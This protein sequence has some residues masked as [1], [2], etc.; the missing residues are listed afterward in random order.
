MSAFDKIIGYENIKEELKWYSDILKNP[1]D[2][3][4]LGVSGP[5]GLLL[6]G[7]PG[8]GKSMMAKALIS[9]SGCKAYTL[10]KNLPNGDFVK[11][12]KRIFDEAA[13]NAP[14]IVLL[15][16]VD[17]FANCD[18]SNKDAEEYVT[19]QACMD[20]YRGKNI[21][22][23]ATANDRYY[24]PDSL[25]RPGRFDK[26]IN[27]GLPNREESAQ[28][29]DYYLKSKAIDVDV[30]SKEVSRL[31]AGN[32]CAALEN[33]I[34]EAGIMAAYQKKPLIQREDI[35]NACIRFIYG[36][37]IVSEIKNIENAEL[38]ALHEAGH[39]VVAEILQP[40]SVNV[41]YLG[42][43]NGSMRGFAAI[44]RKNAGFYDFEG[45]EF[46]ILH[47]LGGKAAVEVIKGKKAVG[48]GSDMEDVF[49]DVRNL[50]ENECAFGMEGYTFGRFG[51]DRSSNRMEEIVLREVKRYY[52]QTKRIITENRL[53]VGA[54]MTALLE[55]RIV[56]GKEIAVIRE[57][58]AE[59]NSKPA[60][61]L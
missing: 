51:S 47:T 31:I 33:V 37:P 43:G 55:K 32:S 26:L 23:V 5:N 56:T 21:F 58:L 60:M 17:K 40:G 7:D 20:E 25:L 36:A 22:V 12:I 11:E 24:L 57:S 6:Y 53:F 29:I 4:K 46:G 61:K 59:K 9:E 27:V 54:V 10:R 30:D 38:T 18:Y 44:Q 1:V 28:I 2:Y 3:E 48:C 49:Q 19:I 39:V 14:S 16:D 52:E 13:A 42:N 35:I 15:D 50:V 8:V 34:N 45:E 41:A